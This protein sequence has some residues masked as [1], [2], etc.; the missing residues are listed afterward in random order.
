MSS[1]NAIYRNHSAPYKVELKP[2]IFAPFYTNEL[3]NAASIASGV[4]INVDLLPLFFFINN[5]QNYNGSPIIYENFFV[6]IVESQI[7]QGGNSPTAFL[8]RFV[9]AVSNQIE[10]FIFGGIGGGGIEIEYGYGQYDIFDFQDSPYVNAF[11]NQQILGQAKS[12]LASTT[13]STNVPNNAHIAIEAI[14]KFSNNA[15]AVNSFI[16]H[17]N[18]LVNAGNHFMVE[19]RLTL[20]RNTFLTKENL[21]QSSIVI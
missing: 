18:S 11:Y 5:K 17:R 13:I 2:N 20:S 16:Q 9:Y 21:T 1:Y 4:N 3:S 15:T 7:L 19:T 6:D 14:H 12:W 8:N 10:K